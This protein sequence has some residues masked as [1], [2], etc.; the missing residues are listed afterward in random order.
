MRKN[1]QRIAFVMQAGHPGH[2]QK[3]LQEIQSCPLFSSIFIVGQAGTPSADM[4]ANVQVIEPGRLSA[5]ASLK[6]MASRLDTP[7]IALYT[8]ALPLILGAHALERMLQVAND[9]KAGMVYSD[10]YVMKENRLDPQAVIDYQEGSLR[11]D[12]NFGSLLLYRSEAFKAAADSMTGDFQFAGLYDLR[13]R[14][15]QAHR[16]IRIPEY[17]YTEMQTDTRTSGEKMFDYV[18]PRNREVQ[19]EMESAC[20]EHLKA[21]GGWLRPEFT[22]VQLHGEGFPVEASV[23]IPV[24]NRVKTIEDA[25]NSVLKQK[26]G[27]PFNLIVVDNHSTDGTTELLSNIAAVDNR[28][29]HCI[30]GRKDLGIGGCWN[31]GVLHEACGRFAIQL[32]SDDLYIDEHVIERIVDAFYGQQCAMVIGSYRMV[33]FLLEDIP[34]GLIDHREWTPDNGRNNALRINGLGAPRAFFTPI[35]RN[36]LFPNVSYGEDYGVGL[37]VSRF[38]QIGRIYEPLYLCRRWEDNTDAA[39]DIAKQNAHNTYKDRLR[40]F[41][42]MARIQLSKSGKSEA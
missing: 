14:V 22:P 17:L 20:T 40:T 6:R 18:D 11:D 8:S 27:F 24:L 23:I 15:S 38:Y 35:L 3:T 37:A 1:D 9:T 42:L 28:L 5:T 21:V 31:F 30:P 39:L 16:L 36:I 25:V 19:I 33:N 32:D 7:F 34:P 10:H 4:P 2:M 13:L 41:E 26:T 12:F 29:I